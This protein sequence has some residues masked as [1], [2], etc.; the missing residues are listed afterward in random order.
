MGDLLAFSK[1]AGGTIAAV[2]L[3]VFVLAALYLATRGGWRTPAGEHQKVEVPAS[4]TPGP[5]DAELDTSIFERL[6]GWGIVLVLFFMIWI[7]AYWLG[8]P[9]ANQAAAARLT[10]D[11]IAR[12]QMITQP[13]NEAVNPGG[14]G[15]VNCHGA[16]LQGGTTLFNGKPYPVPPLYNVCDYTVHGAIKS[17]DDLRH[18]IEQGRAGTPM[19]S[20]SVKYQGAMD[21]QQ[22]SDVINYLI[23]INESSVPFDKNACINPKAGSPTPAPSSASSS[24]S[25]SASATPATSS[26]PM[27]M[28]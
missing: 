21:D 5:A 11:S 8:Q 4:M 10:T 17:V 2:G 12:G 20:W 15:C 22:I 6:Q 19:P 9:D 18:V 28:P 27:A 14:V 13:N 3:V 23:S 24:A 1:S 26:S 25:A 16:D 7:P